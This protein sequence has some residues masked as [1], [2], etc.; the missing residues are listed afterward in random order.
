MADEPPLDYA[1]PMPPKKTSGCL[2]MAVLA[3]GTLVGFVG[4]IV[5]LY[6]LR[7]RAW[8]PPPAPVPAATSPAGGG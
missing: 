4:I 2:F 6:F 3:L 7:S 8:V 1:T 5:L